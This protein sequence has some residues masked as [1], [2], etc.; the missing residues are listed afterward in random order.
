MHARKHVVGHT[1]HGAMGHEVA[2]HSHPDGQFTFV[3]RGLISTETERGVWL[4]PAGRL[5]WIPPGL[6]HSSKA[7]GPVDG[8]LVMVGPNYAKRLPKQISVLR[9]SALLT[10]GLERVSTLTDKDGVLT[11]LLHRLLLLEL[12][13]VE[14]EAFGIPLPRSAVLRAWATGFLQ[15]PSSAL[16]IDAAAK[17]V[18]M[19]RRSFTRHFSQETGKNFSDWKRMVMV[20]S[21]IESLAQ[22]AQ[23][24]AIAY[25]LGYENPSA[26]IAM[27]KAMQGVSPG[28]FLRTH[29]PFGV[30][31]QS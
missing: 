12:E 30:R 27:F 22:G 13:T 20:Q 14:T 1:F 26:F 31:T 29:A 7:R 9:A 17:C 2:M 8:W 6:A 15:A 25:D 3:S 10:A 5:A 16:S 28:R 19:S 23:V 24:S 4:V 18:S 11:R 21:A